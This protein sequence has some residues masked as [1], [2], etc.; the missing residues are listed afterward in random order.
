MTITGL[1]SMSVGY[2]TQLD[3]DIYKS[4]LATNDDSG[5]DVHTTSEGLISPT[6]MLRPSMTTGKSGNTWEV[7]AVIGTLAGEQYHPEPTPWPV[8]QNVNRSV[9]LCECWSDDELFSPEE[10]DK[11]EEWAEA[12]ISKF[13]RVHTWFYDN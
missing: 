1:S 7:M 9:R 11:M 10:L 8:S 2:E 5:K 6:Y 12:V 13:V 4:I 3:I